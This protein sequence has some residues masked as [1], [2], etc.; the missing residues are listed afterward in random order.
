MPLFW[1]LLAVVV[2]EWGMI[3]IRPFAAWIQTVK[4]DIHSTTFQIIRTSFLASIA[5]RY[6]ACGISSIELL[7]LIFISALKMVQ[8]SVMYAIS[9]LL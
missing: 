8:V 2:D 4:S 3:G 9:A 7:F 1:S 5:L 6:Y